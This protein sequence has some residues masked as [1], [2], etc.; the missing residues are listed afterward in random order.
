MTEKLN[1]IE[2]LEKRGNFSTLAKALRQAGLAEMLKGEGPFTLFA[3]TD[4]AFKSLPQDRLN[5]L[6][7][8]EHKEGLQSLLQYHVVRG[9]LMSKD[10]GKSKTPQTLRGQELK[11]DATNGFRV[12]EAKVVTPDIEA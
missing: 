11:I 4:E 2:T 5:D 9:K 10:L 3:P 6:M 8:P 1:I 12:N 7:K